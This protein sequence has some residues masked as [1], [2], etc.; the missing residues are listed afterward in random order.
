MEG[1][2][3]GGRD[4]DGVVEVGSCRDMCDLCLVDFMTK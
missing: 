4:E 1:P 3:E 2:G